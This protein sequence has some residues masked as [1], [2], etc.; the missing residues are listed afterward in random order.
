MRGA[1]R[2][3]S[4]AM[5]SALVTTIT[6]RS[7]VR[8]ISARAIAVVVVPTSSSTVSPSPTMLAA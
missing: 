7:S 4:S 2:S 6:S 1:A 3:S 8:W 5:L